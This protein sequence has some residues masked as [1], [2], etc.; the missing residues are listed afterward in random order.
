M[1]KLGSGTAHHSGLIEQWRTTTFCDI[2]V[3]VGGQV[4]HAHRCVL[5]IGSR[6]MAACFTSSMKD[7]AGPLELPDM[8]SAAFAAVLTYL[9]EGTCEVAM[10][11]IQPLLEA[12][13][14][15]QLPDAFVHELQV[16]LRTLL[17]ADNAPA[18][19]ELADRL[20]LKWLACVCM[21][22]IHPFDEKL[23][24]IGGEDDLALSCDTRYNC[25]AMGE[26]F[27]ACDEED[28]GSIRGWCRLRCRGTQLE[29]LLGAKPAAAFEC[30][31]RLYAATREAFEA[32]TRSTGGS[33]A[34]IDPLSDTVELL[35]GPSMVSFGV[36]VHPEAGNI[37]VTSGKSVYCYKIAAKQW[38]CCPSM[39]VAR[40]EPAMAVLGGCVYAL[41]GNRIEEG[42]TGPLT[43]EVF[44]PDPE[45]PEVLWSPP[46]MSCPGKRQR[47]EVGI[48]ADELL[49]LD[50]AEWHGGVLLFPNRTLGS[51]SGDRWTSDSPTQTLP[52]PPP[53][54]LPNK[55]RWRKLK[56]MPGEHVEGVGMAVLG[57]RLIVIGGKRQRRGFRQENG[58][59]P[60]R[61][62]SWAVKAAWAYDPMTDE[63][64]QLPDMLHE[65]SQACLVAH[66]GGIYA[67]GG[68]AERPSSHWGKPI[69]CIANC[70][71]TGYCC[72]KRQEA[73]D[74]LAARQAERN[75]FGSFGTGRGYV[76]RRWSSISPGSTWA[77]CSVE[78][79][80]PSQ[81]RWVD[82]P[83]LSSPRQGATALLWR[84]VY[85]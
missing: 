11:D 19:L 64:E 40:D 80:E 38:T 61:K 43:L 3:H 53:P 29:K 24:V 69:E 23:C 68:K 13:V 85:I 73:Q 71:G 83:S 32:R 39:T 82:M 16:Q 12:A 33:L 57:T 26:W 10:D 60:Y 65:R 76:D 47:I 58:E 70:S 66:D 75:G 31:G 46:E 42:T 6:F 67:I 56:S 78:R 84:P 1:I 34:C 21:G 48:E 5:A 27:N 77:L 7:S 63:W 59:G 8:N 41:G 22:A 30:G 35:N 45:A 17:T 4:F 81:R 18:M 20:S 54:P 55:G 9:Y 51:F 72:T 28:D 50:G 52:P 37:Y 79:Y 74:A 62:D 49:A 2:E 36:A 25:L 14:R 15:L 44:E